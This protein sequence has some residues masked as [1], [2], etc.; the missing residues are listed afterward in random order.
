MNMV[1]RLQFLEGKHVQVY[2]PG[3]SVDGTVVKVDAD[4]LTLKPRNWAYGEYYVPIVLISM[5]GVLKDQD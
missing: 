4:E 5:I 1:D 3:G 2:T